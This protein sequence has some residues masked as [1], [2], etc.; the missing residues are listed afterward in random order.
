MVSAENIKSNLANLVLIVV[1]ATEKYY[2]A[3]KG[4]KK[5]NRGGKRKVLYV[6][7]GTHEKA[8]IVLLD[9]ACHKERLP[10]NF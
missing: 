1:T 8:L 7:R 5:G 9:D 4:G 6:V 3:M 2:V 10:Q